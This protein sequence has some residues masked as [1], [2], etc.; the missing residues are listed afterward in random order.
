MKELDNFRQ[1]YPD[2]NDLSDPELAGM[3]AKKYPDAYGDLLEKVNQPQVDANPEPLQNVERPEVDIDPRVQKIFQDYDSGTLPENKKKIFELLKNRGFFSV[4]GGVTQLPEIPGALSKE[5]KQ[6]FSN[7][8]RPVISGVTSAGGAMIGT[9]GSPG[10]GTLIG[11]G[12]GYAI[13]EELAD[14][15]DEFMGLRERQPLLVE[16]EE[17]A[18]QTVTGAAFEAGGQSFFPLVAPGVKFLVNK[19]PKIALTGK[20][21]AKIGSKV[22]A[23]ETSSGPI[24]AKNIEEARALEETIPGLKFSRGEITG[25][26]EIIKFERARA[27]APG[28]VATQQVQNAADN[29]AAIK[30]FIDMKKGKGG[31]EDVL[32]PLAKQQGALEKGVEST[33]AGLNK[34]AKV[35]GTG[36]WAV[37][38]AQ[39]IRKAL[40]SGEKSARAEAS[41]LF[42]NVPDFGIDAS[43][44]I[45]TID[46]LSKPIGKF[47]AAGKNIPSE[48]EVIKKVLV[49][50]SGITTPKDLQGLQSELKGLLRDIEGSAAPNNRMSTRVSKLISA[51]DN[52]LKD[53]S[54]SGVRISKEKLKNYYPTVPEMDDYLKVSSKASKNADDIVSYSLG[55]DDKKAYQ[56]IYNEAKDIIDSSDDFSDW[57]QL[58]KS[59]GLNL[60]TAHMMSDPETIK[61]LLRR[62]P[63]L[64]RSGAL[65]HAEHFAMEKGFDTPD[66]L[67]QNW[68]NKKP[69]QESIKDLADDMFDQYQVGQEMG[70]DLTGDSYKKFIDEQIKQTNKLLSSKKPKGSQPER[71]EIVKTRGMPGDKDASE[72]LKTA[73]QFF[74][75]EVIGKFKSGTPGDILKRK[76]GQYKVSNAEI[77]SRFFKA[78]PKGQQS[79]NEFMSAIGKDETALNA[80]KD[81]IKQDLIDNATNPNTGEIVSTKLNSWLSKHKKSLTSYGM[82]NDFNSIKKAQ[83]AYD[84]AIKMQKEFNKSVAS[85]MLNAD[86]DSAVSKAF[87]AGVTKLAAQ[88]LMKQVGGNKKAIN[89]IQ[90]AIIDHILAKSETTAIDFL[91]NNVVGNATFEREFRKMSP[92]ISV[93]F[94]DSPEK[95][96]AL[97]TYRKALKKLQT[98]K[99]SPTLTGGPDTA[100]KIITNLAYSLGAGKSRV[101]NILKAI[102]SPLTKLN[103]NLVNNILNRAAVD[104]DFAYTLQLIAKGK[105]VDMIERRL[106]GHMISLGMKAFNTQEKK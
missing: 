32:D 96:K 7:V 77:A 48:F 73:Q 81:Y 98:L 106:K 22:I 15:L 54:E 83:V 60:E 64:F 75:K 100:E 49:D 72:K 57:T 71:V 33:R 59:G 74:K 90:N 28:D 51:V 102:A 93:A 12:L 58:I 47:E 76:G 56:D 36:Q 44:L 26:P 40:V 80:M 13:G 8:A 104:P 94:K 84:D 30:R 5:G 14:K 37:E 101:L 24:F 69:R 88:K 39:P 16:I 29:S 46:E 50:E 85:K 43:P 9:P 11:G 34:E 61:E 92:A 52:V 67:F 62:R 31:I 45:N 1:K 42:E 27:S 79:A 97:L 87:N 70:E 65:T 2:Y 23:A 55:K 17:S 68:L 99:K 91:G 63:T 18:K 25:D 4:P 41:K 6:E 21:A 82:E 20:G 38:V 3:L 66:E 53:A 95:I 78:G 86:V 105:D 10:V 103:D 19:I 89:G 35:L